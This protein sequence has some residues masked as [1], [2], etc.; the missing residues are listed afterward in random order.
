MHY[1]DKIDTAILDAL[2]ENGRLSNV[3]LSERVGLSESAC[4]RRVKNLDSL[5]VI[6][7]YAA[8]LDTAAVG[9]SGTVFV[10]ASLESQREEQLEAFEEAVK[11]VPEVM[12]CYLMSGEVDYIIRVVVKDAPDYE[13]IHHTLTR[14]PG[15]ARI[16]SSFA[17]RTI[18]KRSKLPLVS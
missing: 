18:L 5:G 11:Y 13:R 16:H 8:H 3:E 2:Q 9:L 1:F 4:L 10:R 17:L 14:L 7:H 6:T 15:V 12:E